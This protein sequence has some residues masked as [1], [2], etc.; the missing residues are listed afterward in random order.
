MIKKIYSDH[1]RFKSVKFH[2]G[3]NLILAEKDSK[4]T[5]GQTRNGAGK[6]SLVE[7]IST[8][9]GGD[10]KKTSLMKAKD[11]SPYR[12]GM[13]IELNGNPV[14]IERSGDYP[15]KIFVK[16]MPENF[17]PISELDGEFF[18]SNEDWVKRLGH[19]CFGLSDSV[20]KIKNGP[21]F[22]SLFSYFVRSSKGF[23]SPDKWF[24]QQ[25]TCSVQVS[26]SYL[27]KLDWKIAREFEGVR[28][29]DKLIKALKE[30]SNE[31]A[32]GDIL[33]SASD[34]RTEI[35]L[36]KSR[37]EKLKSALENFRVLPEY[38]EK[39]KRAS[40]ITRQL[41]GISADDTTDKEWLSQLE[42]ALEDESEVDTAR[43]GRLF[44]EAMIYVPEMVARRFDEV[45]AF[46]ESV[47]RNRREHLQQE[48][49]DIS[50]RISRRY[51]EK[52]A[53]DKER[54]EILSLL[55]AHG[56]LDQY[57]K[58]Q[59]E[60]AKHEAELVQLDKKL[61]ATEDL[62]QKRSELKIGRHN[63]Q[64]KMRI[65]YSE[66]DE[67]ISEAIIA[68][69]EISSNLYDEP[70]KF[71]IDPTNNG[72]KFEFDIPGKKST[73]KSRMQIFCFDMMLMKL[74]ANEP[75]RP[76]TLVHDSIIFDGVDER[77]I[78]KAL[79][80]GAEMAEKHDIQYIVTMNSDDMPDM[81]NYPTFKLDNYRVDLKIT[82]TDTGGLFG[83]RFD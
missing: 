58:F 2:S 33:G 83:F 71:I 36:K 8:L 79:L 9:Y 1:P 59:I 21:T 32:L 67:A 56:A 4:S 76:K 7:I 53:L 23:D 20:A 25:S 12:F 69:A 45:A 14:A 57:M 54:S 31:G 64:Q 17:L 10:L 62:D 55:Q 43:V 80:L 28:Q 65:D 37:V 46:H 48:M 70:G 73:G 75:N 39:E 42:R 66:R 81:S 50:E 82:D 26:L 6:S 34:L 13:D 41:A 74:W 3:L 29:K 24:S 78:A 72:P 11:L 52:E 35:L 61:E 27:L 77:Q 63:L 15:T 49:S 51:A 68:F 44:N 47:V 38:Q 40:D 19:Y 22:R 30:A 18:C 60:L 5:D 16:K